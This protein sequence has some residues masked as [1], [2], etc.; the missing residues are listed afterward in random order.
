MEPR[1]DLL[2]ISGIDRLP[3]PQWKLYNLRKMDPEKRLVAE[4]RLRDRLDL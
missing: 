3:G 2:P 1:W 4:Q